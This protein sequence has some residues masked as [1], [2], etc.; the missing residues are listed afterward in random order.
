[1]LLLPYSNLRFESN[2]VHQK[3]SLRYCGLADLI[4]SVADEF[5]VKNAE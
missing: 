4:S 1:M 3:H 5:R 2:Y